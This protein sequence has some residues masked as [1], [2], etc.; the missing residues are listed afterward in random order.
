MQLRH[1]ISIL[2]AAFVACAASPAG[3]TA[4]YDY[5]A[6]EYVIIDGGLSR[7]TKISLAAHADSGGG[8]FHVW[9][10]AEP[11]HRRIAMLDAI[12]DDNNLD[13]KANAYH[14]EW[15]PDSRHVAVWFRRDR[16][17]LQ[18][19]LYSIDKDRPH[20][21]AGSSLFR[22]VTGR[23]LGNGDDIRRSI[24]S[25]EWR[26]AKRF[27]LRERMLLM[28]ADAGFARRLGRFARIAE[29]HDGGRFLVEFSAEADCVLAV[30]HRYRIADLRPGPF[31]DADGW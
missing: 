1:A 29:R 18:L 20:L 26:S 7:D 6:D 19:N 23:D 2:V 28:T 15:S 10:M 11:A 13:T 3:A 12:G 8:N 5:G 16:H 25:V 24:P 22:D 21:I 27:V 9:L 14:A 17:E 4:E 31:S 30:G